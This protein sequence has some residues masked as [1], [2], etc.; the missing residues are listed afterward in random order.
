MSLQRWIGVGDQPSSG[1]AKDRRV[2]LGQ[3]RSRPGL[4]AARLATS[5]RPTAFPPDSAVSAT[6]SL[7]RKG[8]AVSVKTHLLRVPALVLAVWGRECCFPQGPFCVRF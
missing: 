3:A 4:A 5:A 1:G 7:T 6:D 8:A 2:V